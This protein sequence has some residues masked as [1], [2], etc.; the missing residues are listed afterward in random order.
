MVHPPKNLPHQTD[1][2]TTKDLIALSVALVIFNVWLVRSRRA[3]L[4]RGGQARTLRE[5]FSV[6][7]LSYRAMC[8]V[9]VLKISCAL[10]LLVGIWFETV[11]P[12]AASGLGAL[13]LGALVMH[14]KV[15][16][17]LVKSLPALGLLV[18][19]LVLVFG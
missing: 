5:E 19:C 4:F 3:T 7:G 17:P 12:W 9:G 14:V 18:L 15:R 13:M 11:T 16:D 1:M 2:N 8:L 6:Y 10:A